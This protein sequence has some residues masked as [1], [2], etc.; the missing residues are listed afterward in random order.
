MGFGKLIKE[1]KREF[2]PE[3]DHDAGDLGEYGC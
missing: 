1:A 3:P 2:D